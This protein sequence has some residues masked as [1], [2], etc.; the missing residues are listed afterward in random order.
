LPLE[1]EADIRVLMWWE[2]LGRT[3]TFF[4]FTACSVFHTTR[5]AQKT[6]HPTTILL[7]RVYSLL[8]ERV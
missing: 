8:R 2:V 3:I 1:S 4:P 5:T 7:L 6:S